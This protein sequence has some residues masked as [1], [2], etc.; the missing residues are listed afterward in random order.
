VR[1]A[2]DIFNTYGKDPEAL[3]TITLA[4]SQ[5]LG[6]QNIADIS[7]AFQEWLK[8]KSGMPTPADIL[9]LSIEQEAM[10]KAK[11]VPHR[12]WYQVLRDPDTNDLIEERL[13]ADQLSP[14]QIRQKY[15]RDLKVSFWREGL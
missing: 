10:R 11:E 6:S 2:Y 4:F 13:Y 9:K 15:G 14:V 1:Q 8:Y 3:K 12:P 5:A 7:S